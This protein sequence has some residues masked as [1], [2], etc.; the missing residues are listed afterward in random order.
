MTQEAFNLQQGRIEAFKFNTRLPSLSQ[1][2]ETGEFNGD[3]HSKR[4]Y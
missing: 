2:V 1:S 4:A 3:A